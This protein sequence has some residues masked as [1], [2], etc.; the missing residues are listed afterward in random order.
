[1]LAIAAL[2]FVAIFFF[3]VPFP[4]IVAR[5]PGSIGFVGGRAGLTRFQ[6]GGGHGP[7]QGRGRR[8]RQPRSARSCRPMPGRD[9]A[10]SLAIAAMLARAVARAGRRRCWRSLGRGQRASPDRR[11]LQQDGGGDLRRRLRR[12]RLRRAAGGR[13]YGWLQPGEMLD[14]LGMAETTPGAADHGVQFVGFIAAYRDPGALVAA[15]GRD[16]RRPAHDLGDLRALLP[17]DLPRRALHRGAARPTR[18]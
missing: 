2:A 7:A 15:A 4:L 18:R 1:M 14:G 8:R 17:L 9:R 11:L 5:A 13:D 10:W 6:V 12:A 3:G 16:A